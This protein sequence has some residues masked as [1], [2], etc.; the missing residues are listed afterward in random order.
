MRKVLFASTAIATVAGAMAVANANVTVSGSTEWR[1]H[2]ISDDHDN[3]TARASDGDFNATH[4]VTISFSSTSDSGITTTMSLNMGDGGVSTTTSS[5]SSDFGTIAYNSS[6]SASAGSSYDV[7]APGTSGGYGDAISPT[8]SSGGSTGLDMNEADLADGGGDGAVNYHSPSYS[9]FSFGVGTS[10][11]GNDSDNSSTSF[12]M[13][14]S[15]SMGDV[16]YTIGYASFDGMA[17]NE[18][19]SHY[20]AQVSWGDITV[21]MG[22]SKDKSSDEDEVETLS[23]GATY[24]VSSDL[25]VGVGT[26]TSENKLTTATTDD[27]KLESTSIGVVYTIA[28][29]LTASLA[30][31][32]FD[33]DDGSAA[34]LDNDGTITQ[35]EIK[36]SF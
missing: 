17:E 6:S 30:S 3:T 35:A 25:T 32:S 26:T 12:G 15:G 31:H 23:Y 24:A 36:M 11:I 7:T 4:D 33:Y 27:K 2:S 5:I 29:G 18:E 22:S 16:S 9:G 10:N 28:P 19:A 20:G 21:G 8:N 13:K 14:Y 34:S 1:Y